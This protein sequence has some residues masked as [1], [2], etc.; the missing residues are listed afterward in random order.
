M[1][2]HGYLSR[3]N[4]DLALTAL[5]ANVSKIAKEEI[6]KGAELVLS[7]AKT[8]IHSISGKLSASGRIKVNSSGTVCRIIF[9]SKN[10]EDGYGYAKIVEFRPGHKRPYL[11]NSYDENI[12]QIKQNV[13]DAIRK[14]VHAHAIP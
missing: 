12:A 10:D 2:R 14:E 7:V 8:R 11:Y 1:N 9:D 5:G 3:Q 13:I 4:A 6:K